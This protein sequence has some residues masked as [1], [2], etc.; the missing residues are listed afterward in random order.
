MPAWAAISAGNMATGLVLPHEVR[1][2]VIAADPDPPG[3]KAARAAALRWIA[4]GR[5]VHIAR[6][7]GHGDFNDILLDRASRMGTS[8]H[9]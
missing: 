2:V 9:G 7:N 6:P 4:Q 8:R 3:E 5:T 1:N